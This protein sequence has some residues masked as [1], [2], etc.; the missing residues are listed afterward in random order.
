MPSLRN[1]TLN[2][3]KTKFREITHSILIKNS[4]KNEFE[5]KVK[6]FQKKIDKKC[7]II[8]GTLKD[9]K[10]NIKQV[11]VILHLLNQGIH[12]DAQLR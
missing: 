3:I 10:S 2:S 8:N 9:N 1:R 4:E 5:K 12:L 11:K 6:K 7:G